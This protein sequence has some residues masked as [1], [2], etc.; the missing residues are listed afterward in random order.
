MGED[1]CK[2]GLTAS[3]TDVRCVDT[4]GRTKTTLYVRPDFWSM[5]WHSA[6]YSATWLKGER[7]QRSAERRSAH[8]RLVGADGDEAKVCW[9]V[10]DAEG[11]D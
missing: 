10:R 6:M 8:R 2:N 5:R 11:R 7:C 9:G 1:S 3:A 4:D